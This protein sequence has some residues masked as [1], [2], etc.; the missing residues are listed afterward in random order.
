MSSIVHMDEILYVD[1][2]ERVTAQRKIR[3]SSEMDADI[4]EK[5][6]IKKPSDRQQQQQEKRKHEHN[7][8]DRWKPNIT[9]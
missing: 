8:I 6:E 1:W 4:E 9:E 3:K 2:E 7:P 5:E